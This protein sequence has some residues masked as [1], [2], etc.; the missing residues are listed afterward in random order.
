M[1]VTLEKIKKMD[2]VTNEAYK[3]LRTN[4]TFCGEDVQA[5]ALTSSI[6]NEGKST[7]TFSLARAFA[8]DGK[9][10]LLI[11]A[12]NRKSVLESRYG[13][14]REVKGLSHYLA[15]NA[16]LRD[17]LCQTNIP[18]LHIVF[19]GAV[20]PNPSEL[21]GNDKFGMLLEGA[22]KVYDYIL[23]D[24]PPI[25]SVIDAA[26][27]AK[28]CD[29]AIYVIESGTTSYHIAK[30]G[31]EQLEKSGCRIL[32]AVLNKVDMKSKEYGYGKYYGKY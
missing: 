14:D 21:L 5:I 8:E 23:V 29:G 2:F 28:Q 13:V 26:I 12:D 6:P 25:G 17:V 24:C 1:R 18:N 4:I 19:Q 3:T 7:V 22:R 11:D 31:K 27:V 32:G 10:V 20:A 15:G 9:R 16:E 30:H